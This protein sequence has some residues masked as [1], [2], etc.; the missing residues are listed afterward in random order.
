MPTRERI[1]LIIAAG[2]ALA[3]VAMLLS[4]L[5][6]IDQRGSVTGWYGIAPN[7]ESVVFDD[8]SG[9]SDATAVAWKTAG[10]WVGAIFLWALISLRIFRG[11]RPAQ[12]D[13]E[14]PR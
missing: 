9:D 5:L 11:P 1:I 8:L 14:E 10:I 3:T 12:E 6:T 13:R 2:L 4:S 7:T